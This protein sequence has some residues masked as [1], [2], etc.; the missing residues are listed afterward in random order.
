MR[1]IAAT[2][3]VVV[4]LLFSAGSAWATSR[5]AA[6]EAIRFE[7]YVSKAENGDVDAQVTLGMMY[8]NGWYVAENKAEAFKWFL[9][10]A[11]RHDAMS[12]MLVGWAYATGELV[13]KDLVKAYMWWALAKAQGDEDAGGNL[14]IIKDEMTAADISEAQRLAAEIWEKINN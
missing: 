8:D 10:A 12:Q 5:D 6:D 11:E 9:R 1:R 4:A 13:P 14:D 2:L 3:A 7:K